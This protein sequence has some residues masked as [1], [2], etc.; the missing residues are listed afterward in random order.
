MWAHQALDVKPD[1][2]A[3][4]KKTQVCG[5][6]AGTRVDEVENNVFHESSRINSTWGG[7][8]VDMTRFQRYLEVIEAENLLE[9]VRTTG[10]YLMQGLHRLQASFGEDLITNVRGRGLMQAFDLPTK[11]LRDAFV[12]ACMSN[13]LILMGCG[14][15]SIR[16]R[17]MLDIQRAH[18]DEALALIEK[19]LRSVLS[20]QREA[21]MAEH[22]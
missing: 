6:L 21:A 17:P 19:S 11:Q 12:K 18:V 2:M 22:A 10:A 3:F 7:N 13:G 15:R 9:N 16:V 1:I 4:G 14:N 5:I 8:L 20:G